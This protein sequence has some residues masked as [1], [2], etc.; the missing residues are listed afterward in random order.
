M[1]QTR[2]ICAYFCLL[3]SL[4]KAH[5]ELSGRWERVIAK[6]E[7][8]NADLRHKCD[9]SKKTIEKLNGEVADLQEKDAAK[10]RQLKTIEEMTAD[11]SEK[12]LKMSFEDIQECLRKIREVAMPGY[13]PHPE[14]ETAEQQQATASSKKPATRA[15]SAAK[16]DRRTLGSDTV[17]SKNVSPRN[18][19]PALSVAKPTSMGRKK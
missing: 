19:P 18:R 11:A 8:D 4:L 2:I 5:T 14:E 12:L 10:A 9:E 3:Q 16:K 15:K 6:H 7:A 13:L 17:Q 1:V